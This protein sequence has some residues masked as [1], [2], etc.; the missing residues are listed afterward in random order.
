VPKSTLH[1]AICQHFAHGISFFFFGSLASRI[2][3]HGFS[4]CC[5]WVKKKKVSFFSKFFCVYFAFSMAFSVLVFQQY[6]SQVLP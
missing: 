1:S 3:H 6:E 5:V 4:F 2:M